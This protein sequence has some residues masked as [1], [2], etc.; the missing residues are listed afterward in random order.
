MQ[1]CPPEFF[2]TC[3]YLINCKKKRN[4]RGSNKKKE[5][6]NKVL[7]VVLGQDVD[8]VML[9]ESWKAVSVEKQTWTCRWDTCQSLWSN[10]ICWDVLTGIQLLTEAANIRNCVCA[11]RTHSFNQQNTVIHN[12]AQTGQQ[13]QGRVC[14]VSWRC[15]HWVHTIQRQWSLQLCFSLLFIRHQVKATPAASETQTHCRISRHALLYG[16]DKEE[17]VKQSMAPCVLSGLTHRFLRCEHRRLLP[18]TPSYVVC[19]NLRPQTTLHWPW[20]DK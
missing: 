13:M 8:C 19:R 16:E 15:T 6:K 17:A 10:C 2:E 11:I 12:D 5:V 3:P 9:W 18:H 20:I 1:T 4:K 14:G 7:I